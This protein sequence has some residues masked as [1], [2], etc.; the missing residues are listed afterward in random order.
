VMSPILVL[1]RD[2][3]HFQLETDVSGV[4]TGAVLLQQQEDSSY[5][6]VGY[7]LKTLT[8]VEQNYMTYNKDLLTIMRAL[9]DWRNLLLG[10]HEPFD[11]YTDHCNLVYFQD[12]QKLMSRQAN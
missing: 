1:P 5:H 4:A 8:A 3:G 12:P 7:T 10:A 11:I 6:P 9:E 2:Q